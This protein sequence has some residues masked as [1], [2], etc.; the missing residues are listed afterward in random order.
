[1]GLASFHAV[2]LMNVH[3]FKSEVLKVLHKKHDCGSRIASRITSP[4]RY[5]F[6]KVEL[7]N[8]GKGAP[9]RNGGHTVSDTLLMFS[10]AVLLDTLHCGPNVAKDCIG[11]RASPG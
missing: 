6:A 4:F 7:I 5:H 9:V 10:V 1:M 11:C 3:A 8:H 2:G